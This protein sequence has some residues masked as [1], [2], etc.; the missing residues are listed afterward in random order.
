MDTMK[1]SASVIGKCWFGLMALSSWVAC[2]PVDLSDRGTD[3]TSGDTTVLSGETATTV[4][5][6]EQT[7]VR[8]SIP[9]SSPTEVDSTVGA[10]EGGT[11]A[12]DAATAA[13]TLTSSEGTVTREPTSG[14]E[15]G[16]EDVPPPIDAFCIDNQPDAL[17]PG[18]V[19]FAKLDGYGV[20][21]T[22]GG[23]GGRL[24]FVNR[25][26]ELREHVAS[27][28]P[29]V[30][31]LCGE[32][33]LSKR[34]RISSNKSLLGIGPSSILRGGIDVVGTEDSVVGN[35]IIANLTIDGSTIEPL[36]DTNAR[37]GIRIQG[38]H[39]VWLDHLEV[40]DA[41]WGLVDVIWG[42]DLVTLSWNKFYF[43]DAAPDAE[44]RFG[45]RVGDHE[46]DPNPSQNEGRLR[47]T[48]HHNW[49]GPL[50]RQRAPRV[51]YGLVH[52]LN[53]YFTSQPVEGDTIQSTLWA[54]SY[55]RVL[56]ESNYFE[57][58]VNPH[59]VRDDTA[60]LL[61]A[62][63]VY[64]GTSGLQQSTSEA[65]TPTYT[66]TRDST[67]W[68]PALVPWGAGPHLELSPPPAWSDAGV[69]PASDAGVVDLVDASADGSPADASL[70]DVPDAN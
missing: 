11:R 1:E 26:A 8:P 34:L 51:A 3:A 63:N 67:V 65:F 30:V 69:K 27:A 50:I 54:T 39:H 70:D 38:A 48:L 60:N 49:F 56:L 37:A 66:Y 10:A 5:T 41:P 43:T 15:A 21:Q 64:Y 25:E 28:E 62:H 24:V 58:T 19:G 2:S 7:R 52:V 22:M 9:P 17:P 23:L 36:T 4:T 6:E 16:T 18:L 46:T 20:G 12:T 68:L 53:N 33:S 47:T 59:E 45:V 55:A 14:I 32:V 31:V 29:M 42:S 35:V 44:H 40:Y 13:L 57:Y 61:A